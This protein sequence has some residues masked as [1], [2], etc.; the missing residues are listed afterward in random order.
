MHIFATMPDD[1]TFRTRRQKRVQ[2]ATLRLP[3]IGKLIA[4]PQAPEAPL[5]TADADALKWHAAHIAEAARLG[6][7]A[8]AFER[9]RPELLDLLGL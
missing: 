6:K 7:I 5:A 9:D 1:E 8:V 3:S 2:T 4:R